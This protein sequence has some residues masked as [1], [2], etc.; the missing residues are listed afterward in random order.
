MSGPSEASVCG[1][2][3]CGPSG[4]DRADTVISISRSP[5][6]Q[7]EIVSDAICPWCY[8]AKRNLDAAV[9]EL[10]TSFSVD[11]K[12]RPFELSP[13]MPKNGLDRKE[14]RSAKFGSWE[15]SQRLDAHVAEAGKAAGLDFHHE[16][17]ERTPN[18][19]D[20][21]RLIWLAEREGVQ[22]TVVEGLFAGYF[23]EGRDVGDR[24]VLTQIAGRAGLDRAKVMAFLE[25]DDGRDEVRLMA[26][27]AYASGFTGVPTI[28]VNGNALFSGA[29]STET[30]LAAMRSAVVSQ[31]SPSVAEV[32]PDAAGR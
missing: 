25:G 6:L 17:M 26:A 12:W 27:T 18:T 7:I 1:I 21:H 20:A 4:D 30:M 14:Y 28:L 5:D 2:D 13:D 11:V 16:R 29:R 3:G 10:R 32:H 9:A 31:A 19:F 15:K 24:E 22:D 23:T 8:V